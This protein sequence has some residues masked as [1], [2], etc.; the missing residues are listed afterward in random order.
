MRI[1]IMER[2]SIPSN[3]GYVSDIHSFNSNHKEKSLN[4]LKSG[5]CFGL[6]QGKKHRQSRCSL[7]PLK[8]GLC[9][10]H[11]F[12]NLDD[13]KAHVSIPSNRGY[14]SDNMSKRTFQIADGRLN[15]L[16][17]GLCFGPNGHAS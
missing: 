15:P 6:K 2:V 10:G 11:F 9:F 17:S 7:N 16:K 4:P 1:G 5:L 8:S 12:V 14:V 3:R 13:S